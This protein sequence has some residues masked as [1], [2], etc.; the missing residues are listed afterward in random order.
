M[1]STVIEMG[2][3]AGKYVEV[4]AAQRLPVWSKRFHRVLM[5]YCDLTGCI[6][7]VSPKKNPRFRRKVVSVTYP[8][9]VCKDVEAHKVLYIN[10]LSKLSR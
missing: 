6:L 8:Y 2:L 9:R 5:F 3:F 7:H 10:P 4:R 1:R